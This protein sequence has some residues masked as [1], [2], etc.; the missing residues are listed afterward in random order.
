MTEDDCFDKL[1]TSAEC[2]AVRYNLRNA[3][4]VNGYTLV[5]LWTTNSQAA[6]R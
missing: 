5:I 3:R 6:T 2:S 4:T 1:S